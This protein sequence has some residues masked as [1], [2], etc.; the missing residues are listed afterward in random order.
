MHGLFGIP[1]PVESS[2]YA[3]GPE[4]AVTDLHGDMLSVE[5]TAV[6]SRGNDS[7]E[8]SVLADSERDIDDSDA[9]K[10][11]LELFVTARCYDTIACMEAL[12]RAGKIVD[13]RISYLVPIPRFQGPAVLDALPP[14]IL[15]GP[16][17]SANPLD[18]AAAQQQLCLRNYLASQALASPGQPRRAYPY[19]DETTA[20]IAWY[21]FVR[22]QHRSP[23]DIGKEALAEQCARVIRVPYSGWWRQCSQDA[24]GRQLLAQSARHASDRGVS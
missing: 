8:V 1:L 19:T 7:T 6:A 11:P 15:L 9:G 21:R 14:G 5:N 10:V 22:C 24:Q 3:A 2:S 12:E 17:C 23:E 13:L 4:T 20:M 18:C 16:Y